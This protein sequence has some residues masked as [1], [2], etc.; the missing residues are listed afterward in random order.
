[1]LADGYLVCGDLSPQWIHFLLGYGILLQLADDLQDL[2]TD[3][4][5]KH[6][7]LFSIYYQHK[8]VDS[9]VQKLRNFSHEVFKTFPGDW[10]AS[11]K[12]LIEVMRKAVD[13]LIFDAAIHVQKSCQ[14]SYLERLEK[15]FPV[16][17]RQQEN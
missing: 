11:N 12:V 7:T 15:Q 10:S 13:Y 5:S 6:W 8:T 14:R 9:Q 4:A 3:A 16:N 1:M 2:Y 17:V